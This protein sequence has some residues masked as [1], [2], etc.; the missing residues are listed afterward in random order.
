MLVSPDK[1]WLTDERDCRQRNWHC[2]FEPITSCE[3]RA[4]NLREIP[5]LRVSRAVELSSSHAVVQLGYDAQNELM[6]NRFMTR[7][8]APPFA[9]LGLVWWRAMLAKFLL[10]P[11]QTVYGLIDAA[12]QRLSA[13]SK[14]WPP[15]IGIH[16]RHGDK[17]VEASVL[18]V[19][20]YID[21]ATALVRE[22]RGRKSVF[23]SSDDPDVLHI[24]ASLGV[25]RQIEVLSDADELRDLDITNANVLNHRRVNVTRY[26]LEAIS[27]TWLLSEA[28]LFVGTFSSNL[29]R[30]AFELMLANQ[31]NSTMKFG[32]SLDLVW[33]AYP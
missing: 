24:A 6:H 30:L 2:Y 29:G 17:V 5:S 26:A 9:R 18:D 16:V 11:I 14:R 13:N 4:D 21:V 32:F 8:V 20:A 33:Y 22:S 23:I 19:A 25:Q 3:F 27:N 28:Q 31:S 7:F 12:R 1:W 10:R 15:L